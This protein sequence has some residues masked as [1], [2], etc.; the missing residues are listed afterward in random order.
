MNV[1]KIYILFH[2]LLL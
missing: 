1:V 2:G